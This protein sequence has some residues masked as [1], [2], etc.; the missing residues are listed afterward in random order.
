MNLEDANITMNALNI[1]MSQYPLIKATDVDEI[2]VTGP[3]NLG[4][5]ITK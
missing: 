1:P 5:F 4:I 3:E 2:V